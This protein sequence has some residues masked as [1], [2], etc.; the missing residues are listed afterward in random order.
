M[1]ENHTELWHSILL[2]NSTGHVVQILSGAGM[3]AP[4]QGEKA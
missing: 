4:K 2:R 1:C 3:S